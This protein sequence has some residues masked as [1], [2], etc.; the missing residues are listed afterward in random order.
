MDLSAEKTLRTDL[1]T[2]WGCCG[3]KAGEES[4]WDEVREQY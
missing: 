2:L 3:G 4:Q 1:W